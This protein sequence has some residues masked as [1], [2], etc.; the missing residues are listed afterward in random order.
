MD[1]LGRKE[2]IFPR[3]CFVCGK[4][5]TL[6]H[7]GWPILECT[8]CDVTEIGTIKGRFHHQI[9]ETLDWVGGAITL[10]D[11]SKIHLPSPDMI[12]TCR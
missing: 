8:D 4:K 1:V 3:G 7:E 12:G 2:R 10:V 11:H 9:E 5:M 6:K